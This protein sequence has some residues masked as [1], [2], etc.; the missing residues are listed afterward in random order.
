[1]QEV[2]NALRAWVGR[3][4][5]PSS[6][7]ILYFAGHGLSKGLD[8]LYLLRDYGR[9]P[10]DPLTGALNYQKFIMGLA[11]RKPSQQFLLFDACRSAAPVAAF[12]PTGGEGIF[13]AD[14]EGRLGIAEKMQQC[15]VFSTESDE[16][17]RGRPGEESLCARAFIRV[18]S[19]ACSKREGNDWYVRTDRIVEALTEFQN[20]ELTSAAETIRQSADANRHAKIRLRKLAGPPSIPVFVCLNDTTLAPNVRIR[21]VRGALPPK[22]ISDP[23]HPGWKAQPEWETELEIGEYLFEAKP[24]QGGTSFTNKQTVYPILTEVKL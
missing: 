3:A 20:R 10:D 18:M 15:P 22:L 14:P 6:R 9:N 1:M 5:D 12:N 16:E 4:E 19:G 24:L 7:I 23:G 8:N 17:S 2:R 13:M 21:A 11:T